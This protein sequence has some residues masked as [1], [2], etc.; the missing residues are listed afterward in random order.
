MK[1]LAVAFT[2]LGF[3]S[4]GDLVCAE[5]NVLGNCNAL[6]GRLRKLSRDVIVHLTSVGPG[7]RLSHYAPPPA[8][9]VSGG[10]WQVASTSQCVASQVGTPYMRA[11]SIYASCYFAS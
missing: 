8:L 2:E 11:V 10:V 9:C 3:V 5:T 4:A 1:K 6:D 7:T